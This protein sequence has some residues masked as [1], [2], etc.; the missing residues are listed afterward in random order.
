[1]PRMA[2]LQV[3]ATGTGRGPVFRNV[4]AHADH[5]IFIAFDFEKL[6]GEVVFNGPEHV[7]LQDMPETWANQRPVSP[8]RIRVLNE[9]VSE[10]DRLQI[11]ERAPVGDIPELE[12]TSNRKNQSS[13]PSP[14]T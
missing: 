5:L 8:Q 10:A 6:E 7:A 3:K 14:E 9:I 13:P 11:V 4:D 2:G 12:P 1:M